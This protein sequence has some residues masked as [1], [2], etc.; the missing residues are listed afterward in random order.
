MFDDQISS[1]KVLEHFIDSLALG[2]LV[3]DP[4]GRNR[5]GTEG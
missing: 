3:A 1:F 4:F 2:T 5:G